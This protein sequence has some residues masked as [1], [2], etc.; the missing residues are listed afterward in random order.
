MDSGIILKKENLLAQD[1]CVI[2]HG[3]NAHG[4]MN[5]GVAKAIR[6]KWPSAWTW[7]RYE[8]EKS[9]AAGRPH[10]PLG[11]IFIIKMSDS[12]FVCDAITQKDYGRDS[13]VVYADY[14]AIRLAFNTLNK[15]ILRS[16]L[17]KRVC[18]PLIGCGLANGD[19]SIVEKIIDEELDDSI[20]KI[21]CK[22][23]SI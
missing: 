21:L 6:G 7:Y 4:V 8:Y 5:S 11:E 12:L 19:W 17:P 10:L 9:I 20:E 23:D 16:S 22:P 3:C 13:S 2:I 14:D 1:N 18:F 15:V